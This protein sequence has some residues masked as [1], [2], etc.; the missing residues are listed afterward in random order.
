MTEEFTLQ[1]LD[2]LAALAGFRYDTVLW[3]AKGFTVVLE[4]SMGGE[5]CFTGGTTDLAIE[6]ACR[7]LSLIVERVH[8]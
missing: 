8:G 6:H 3:D 5:L 4:D 1:R 7:H 2:T